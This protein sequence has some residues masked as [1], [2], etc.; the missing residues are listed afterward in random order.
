MATSSVSST[1]TST[2]LLQAS[3]R[4]GLIIENSDANRLYVLLGSGTAS[5]S[6]FSFSLAQNENAHI[7]GYKGVVTG[8]WAADGSGSALVTEIDWDGVD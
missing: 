8:I 1:T 4:A 6:N 3:N 7:P 2:T 5:G